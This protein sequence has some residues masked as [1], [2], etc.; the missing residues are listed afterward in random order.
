M[1]FPDWGES[2]RNLDSQQLPLFQEWDVDWDQ[3]ML[4]LREGQPYTVSGDQALKIWVYRALHLESRRF[5]YTAWSFDYGNELG[6]LVGYGGDRGILE[7]LLRR[8]I[9]EALLICPYIREVDGFSF[10]YA[11]SKVT[12]AFYVTTVYSGFYQQT[13]VAVS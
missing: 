1:I 11:G 9:R 8:Y 6:E 3:N 12:A 7:S 2:I 5:F 4:A 10:S 13:E